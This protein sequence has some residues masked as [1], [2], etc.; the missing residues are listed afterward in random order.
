MTRTEHLAQAE[1]KARAKL[2]AGQ[3]K[4]AR[5]QARQRALARAAEEHR[6]RTLGRLVL[7]TPLGTLDD[8]TLALLFRVLSTLVDV[9][10]PVAML[11]G[12]LHEGPMAENT[13]STTA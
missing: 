4:L 8:L 11:E 12:L 1:A 6:Q 10:D 3:A 7:E 2:A 5:I 9:Q 13:P